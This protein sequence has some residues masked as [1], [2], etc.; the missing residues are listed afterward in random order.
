MSHSFK[1]QLT[2]L[3]LDYLAPGKPVP[4]S[5]RG[6]CSEFGQVEPLKGEWV[7]HPDPDY[8]GFSDPHKCPDFIADFD[9]R[10]AYIESQ[11]A[12][13]RHQ[14]FRKV[15]KPHA[16]ELHAWN[17]SHFEECLAGR[18]I[19]II[20]DSTMRQAFQSLACLLT[21]QILSGFFVD[22][23]NANSS[24]TAIPFEREY[25]VRGEPG[26]SV[27]KQ[28]IG[29]FTLGN[30]AAV[31]IQSFGMFNMTLWD[32]VM[33]QF[34][35][36]TPRDIILVEFGAWYPRFNTFK[37]QE[38]WMNFLADMRDL[39]ELRLRKYHAQVLW[40]AYGPTHFGG[41]TGS[42]TAMESHLP[43]LPGQTRCEVASHGEYYYDTEIIKY[44]RNECGPACAH[45]HVLPVYHLSLLAHDSH[46][47]SFG[48]GVPEKR[49][50]CRHFCANVID[51]WNQV[52]YNKLC[53]GR[54]G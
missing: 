54:K 48:R 18:R 32:D 7:P 46:H 27:F 39:F 11:Y 51:T 50:D 47:G 14:E 6:M 25:M 36:L 43:D 2:E 45:I 44:L 4:T 17:A 40:R 38:P 21:D 22:W 49:I 10:A 37:G 28:N 52:L 41:P 5:Q 19:I 23:E 42:Y 33:A 24:Q 3:D 26:V 1:R 13:L 53:F 31:H 35:P 30:G 8:Q 16:C 12:A 29:S 9:C 15:F 34:M 20:G